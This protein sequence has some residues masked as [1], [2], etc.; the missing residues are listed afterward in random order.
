MLYLS[1]VAFPL[2]IYFKMPLTR[3]KVLQLFA[4]KMQA[5]MCMGSSDSVLCKIYEHDFSISCLHIHV[6][7]FDHP[8]VEL[9]VLDDDADVDDDTP[10]EGE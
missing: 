6:A 5:Y 9:S 4:V 3:W 7:V 10:N 1:T 8:V 2:V